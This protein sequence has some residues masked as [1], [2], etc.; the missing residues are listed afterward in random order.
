MT[1]EPIDLQTIQDCENGICDTPALLSELERWRKLGTT[2]LEIQRNPIKGLER[3]EWLHD[4]L[5][6]LLPQGEA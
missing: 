3:G 2:L 6:D 1:S 5:A 4:E